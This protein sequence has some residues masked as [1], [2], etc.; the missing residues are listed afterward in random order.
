MRPLIFLLVLLVP[1]AVFATVEVYKF[2]DPAMGERYTTLTHELRCLV[3]QNENLADSNADLAHD[4]RQEVYEMLKAGKTD[5]QI[6]GFMV[7][8]YGDFVLYR[9]PLMRTTL[10]LWGGPFILLFIA[11]VVMLRFIL[12]RGRQA[13]V[14]LSD[15]DHHML[16]GLLNKKD[17]EK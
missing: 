14:T 13:P 11:I 12:S 16:Q 3:C 2:S 8:R 4:L 10:L 17:Q 9:P 15:E 5:K 1:T 7:Q 6:V